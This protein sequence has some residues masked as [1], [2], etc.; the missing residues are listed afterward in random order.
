M[1]AAIYGLEGP[2]LT[3]AE[4]GFLKDADPQGI[5]LFARNCE[6]PEQLRTLTDS[7][8]DLTGR[9]DLAILIDQEGGRV[10]RM[11]PPAWPGFPPMGDFSRL[12]EK[13]PMS[14]IEAARVNALALGLMLAEAGINVNALPLLD[15]RQPGAD[16]IIGDRALGTDPMQVAALGRAVLDGLSARAASA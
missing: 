16:E 1:Q 6:S 2:L 10:A 12:Y 7:L 13:A 11:K 14:A 8:R 3:D 15:V 4:R 9:D 5:I